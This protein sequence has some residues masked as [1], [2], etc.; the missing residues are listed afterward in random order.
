M[1]VN[2]FFL[3]YVR[4]SLVAQWVRL[5]TPNAGGPGSIPGWGTRSC[6]HTTTK[7]PH[8]ATQCSLKNFKTV[9]IYI[10]LHW[11]F[12]AVHRFFSSCRDY[13]LTVV[14]RLFILTA[15]LVA[16]HKL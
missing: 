1:C 3:I 6:K 9:L 12:I 13:S 10:W 15:S 14:R 5:G 2:V 16:E 4:E 11:V 7:S 8:A